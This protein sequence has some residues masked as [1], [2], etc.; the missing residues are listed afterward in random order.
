MMTTLSAC[1][2]LGERKP[3]WECVQSDRRAKRVEILKDEKKIRLHSWI[4][5]RSSGKSKAKFYNFGT[6]TF[7]VP[8]ENLRESKEEEKEGV[9]ESKVKEWERNSRG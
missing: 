5:L 1:E 4:H 6:K 8:P 9:E 3:N 2:S 7:C